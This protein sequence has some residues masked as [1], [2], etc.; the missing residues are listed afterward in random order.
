MKPN[1]PIWN[2]LLYI[3]VEILRENQDHTFWW[4]NYRDASQKLGT[5]VHK[6]VR[7]KITYL[8]SAFHSLWHDIRWFSIWIFKMPPSFFART[9]SQTQNEA[10][11][12][13]F[14]ILFKQFPN[15]ICI[16]PAYWPKYYMHKQK[17][18]GQCFCYELFM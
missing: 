18:C 11:S 1:Y 6:D 4:K 3:Y 13:Y 8:C 7:N 12:I 16:L 10:L 5:N 17:T 2:W 9:V 14:W 15:I